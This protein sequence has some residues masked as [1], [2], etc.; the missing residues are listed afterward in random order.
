MT[1]HKNIKNKNM[2][3]RAI[4]TQVLT[5]VLSGKR[6]LTDTLNK[7]KKHCKKPEDAAFVQALCFGV[8]RA[9]P[10]LEWM[11][12]QLLKHPLK[13]K[14]ADILYLICLGLYQLTD[15]N[16]ATHAA[17][18][19]TVEAAKQLKKPWAAALINAV[20]RNFLR[21]KETLLQTLEEEL[22]KQESLKYQNTAWLIQII[23]KSWPQDFEQIM[24]ANNTQAPLVLRVNLNKIQREAYLALLDKNEI[25]ASSVPG[26]IAG[27]VLEAACDLSK[28]PGF[29]E[30]LVS[31]QDGAAQLAA[32]LLEPLENMKILDAC[33]APGGKTAH[34]LET[35]P[36]LGELLALDISK[37][38]CEKIIE[39]LDRLQINAKEKVNVYVIAGDALQPKSWWDG[40]L[41]DRIL[42]D[43]PCSATGVIRRH[44]DIKFLRQASDIPA[45]AIQQLNLLKTLWPLLKPNGIL[46]Y[47]TCSIL[48]AENNE[49]IEKFLN[50]EST[51]ALMPFTIDWGQ[52]LAVGHQLLPGQ[53]NMDGFYY[54]R[55]RKKA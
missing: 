15:L 26:T 9:Y 30:G 48:P 47:A 22:L 37:E 27:I 25:K 44:P 31:V 51:A 10:R 4:A 39:N 46:L 2:N 54:A 17:I 1:D 29:D 19:E 50:E 18:S 6:S 7:F 5:E 36:N 35:T 40:K 53:N 11:A 13:T 23:K 33:A 34:I 45:L 28:L 14:D 32:E 41:F 3:S 12:N 49:V 52:V 55:I 21:Q 42:L 43:A 24:L 38:R 20:L 16:T 8:L